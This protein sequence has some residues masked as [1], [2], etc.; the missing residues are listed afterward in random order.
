ME[1]T[2]SEYPKRPLQHDVGDRAVNVFRYKCPRHWVFNEPQRDYGW[3][4]L[5]TIKK[6]EQ[7]TEDFFAQ[8]KGS[9][10]PNFIDNKKIVSFELKITTV[11]W[12]LHK[13]LPSML[14]VCDTGQNGEPIYYVWIQEDINRINESNPNWKTQDYLT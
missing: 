5:V 14:C 6:D 3:D 7:V 4:I 13:P 12:L 2:S 10:K 11:N 8:L 1:K 9:D